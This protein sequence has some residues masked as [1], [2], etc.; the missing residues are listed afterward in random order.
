MDQEKNIT[1]KR[2]WVHI[3]ERERYKIE[4]LHEQGL[5]PSQIG[6]ALNPVRD[7]RTIERELK[8]GLVEQKRENP[9]YNKYAP[10]YVIEKVYKADTAQMRH[11]ERASNKGR[12]LKIGND[13]KLAD[14]IENKIKEDKWSPDKSRR[15]EIQYD[16]LH[17][18]GLQ[19][20][21]QRDFQGSDE[22]GPV[23][24]ERRW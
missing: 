9:S 10:M 8:L 18:N 1:E 19:L 2:K 21:R 23:G 4:A 14:Y 6:N 12:G 11:D 7:R 16:H 22:Q 24:E 20:H 15:L 13:Q 5:T 3:S 17:E